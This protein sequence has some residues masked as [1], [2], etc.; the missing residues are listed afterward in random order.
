MNQSVTLNT[1]LTQHEENYNA[2]WKYCF[3]I[4]KNVAECFI[5]E[6]R[7]VIC[8]IGEHSF[9]AALMPK[10]DG[11]YFMNINQANMKKFGIGPDNEIEITLEKDHS[12]YGMPLPLEL[13]E[14]WNQDPEGKRVFNDL[15]KGKQR[16]LV[17]IIGKIKSADIRLKKSIIMM[18]YLKSVGGN[19]DF[20]E[21]NEAFKRGQ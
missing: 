2:V 21:L 1:T 11:N 12:E 14:L 17:H 6:N 15:T 7:R 19:L 5:K 10:G 8:H 4:P 13:E 20:K 9:H 18:E 16:N 3:L